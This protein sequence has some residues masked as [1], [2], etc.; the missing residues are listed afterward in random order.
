MYNK[1]CKK[2]GL[3]T[4]EAFTRAIRCDCLRMIHDAKSGHP[5]GAC[6]C[7]D[8]LAVLYKKVLNVPLEWDKAVDFN[9]RDRFV[10]SKGHASTALYA[11]LAH[12]G[13]FSKDLLSGFR[14]LGSKLQGHPSS[15]TKLPGIEVSTGSLGQ[16]LSIAVG[17]ALALRLDKINSKVFVL[18]GDGEMQEGSVWE[19]LMNA[20][21]KKLDNL[22]V[23]ID[24]NRL[25]IDGLVDEVK[26]LEPL[27]EKFK[28]FGFDVYEIDGHNYEQIESILL[29]AKKS[30]KLTAIIANTIK[31]KGVSF[32]ENNPSWHGKAPNDEELKKALEELNV[33]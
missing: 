23:I 26:S 2:E 30:N 21:A 18:M 32:M 4:L 20:N 11:T 24:K 22:V 13:Y 19:S 15:R 25:Q 14:K 8:I 27:D 16:G 7:V 10:L 1:Y 29:E 5:G 31:G 12:C 33:K 3:T 28:A 9:E 6:S 17:I